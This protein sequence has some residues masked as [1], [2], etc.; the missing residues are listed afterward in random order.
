MR[1][2]SQNASIASSRFAASDFSAIFVY[3][4][5]FPSHFLRRRDAEDCEAVDHR[6][7]EGAR[8]SLF[9]RLFGAPEHLFR[10]IKSIPCGGEFREVGR[11]E[12]RRELARRARS[13]VGKMENEPLDSIRLGGPLP[14]PPPP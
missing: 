8:E 7:R 4:N 5:T 14:A 13:H 1:S 6:V 10:R 12:I 9:V 2:R 3:P 11:E